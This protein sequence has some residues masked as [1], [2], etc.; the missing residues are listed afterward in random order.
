MPTYSHINVL[1]IQI[2][3][4]QIHTHTHTHTNNN[5]SETIA[6]LTILIAL[7]MIFKKEASSV[8]FFSLIFIKVFIQPNSKII[9]IDLLERLNFGEN[10]F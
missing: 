8:K 6:I 10:K 1:K 3:F 2:Q 9:P 5:N 4:F 7:L